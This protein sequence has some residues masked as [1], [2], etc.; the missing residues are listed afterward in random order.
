LTF[1]FEISSVFRWNYE[2]VKPIVINQGGTSSGKTYSILQ[3]LIC[4]CLQEKNTVVTVVGQDVPNLKSGAI[5]DF[6]TIIETTPFFSRFLESVNRTDKTYRFLNGSIMEFKSYE[7]EQDAKSGKRK[8]LFV[9]EANGIPFS[10]YD[11]LQIRT[12][13]QVFLDY[14]PTFAFWVHDKLIGREDVD[15][16]ISSYKHNSF[17]SADIVRKIEQLRYTDPN[18]WKVYGL[19][20]TGILENVIFDRVEW[21]SKMPEVL[22]RVSFGVDFGFSADPTTIVKCGLSEGVLY[23]QLL[24]Y[25]KGLTNPDIGREFDRLGIKK[26]RRMGDIIMCDSAEPKSIRELKNMNWNVKGCKKGADSIR[27][28]INALKS[29]GVL[30]LVNSEKWKH[31]QRS[32]IWQINRKDGRTQNK[33]IDK[34][35]HIWDAF[36][37]AEQAIRK[38]VYKTEYS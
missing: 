16:F 12:E 6:E 25:D 3:V 7:N 34:N 1:E 18:K 31:E 27:H 20:K 15:L 35:N 5:R 11:Q 36:R 28:G 38:T 33:P 23:G 13:K 19:G 17:I 30:N 10:V 37:Y 24:L 14:N 8:Y 26:G 4:K 22:K 2:S 32:Y 29:Y 9:N 21:V